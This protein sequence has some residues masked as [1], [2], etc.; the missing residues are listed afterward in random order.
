[1]FTSPP[2]EIHERDVVEVVG[3]VI[4]RDVAVGDPVINCVSIRRT[5]EKACPAKVR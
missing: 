2:G 1:M 5:G 3:M 4:R